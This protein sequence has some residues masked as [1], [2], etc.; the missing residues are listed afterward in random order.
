MDINFSDLLKFASLKYLNH[1]AIV[2]VN[3]KKISYQELDRRVNALSNAFIHMGLCKNDKLAFI[4]PNCIEAIEIH[5]ATARSGIVAI[6]LNCNLQKEKLELLL[7]HCEPSAIICDSS[8]YRKISVFIKKTPVKPILICIGDKTSKHFNYNELV[9]RSSCLE[10]RTVIHGNDFC[11]ILYTSG[12]TGTPKGAVRTHKNNYWAAIIMALN[13]N[14]YE[15]DQ[16]LFVLPLWSVAFYNLLCPNFIKGGTIYLHEGF[17]TAKILQA[18]EEKKITRVYLVPSMW[19]RLFGDPNFSNYNLSS[20]KQ[21]LVGSSPIPVELGLKMHDIFPD[22]TIYEMWGMTEGGLISINQNDN[23]TRR[24]LSS[25]GKPVPFTYVRIVNDYGINVPQGDIG[26]IIISGPAVIS[27]YYKS[28]TSKDSFSPGSWF[29]T[30]DLARQDSDG[31]YYI[32]GRKS[33]VILCGDSNVYPMEIEMVLLSHPQ[34][35]EVAVFG[36]PDPLLGETVVAAIIP[37]KRSKLNSKAINDYISKYLANDKVPKHFFI[38]SSFPVT[39]SGKII[40]PE[41]KKAILGKFKTRQ[42]RKGSIT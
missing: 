14:Y 39:S 24:R 5:F 34:I 29:R 18:I 35:Q 40:K 21:A 20:L 28:K 33:D 7:K 38:D 16:E 8:C 1:T 6:P 41:V 19:N 10:P 30:G 42:I 3:G 4:L 11:S 26:E 27:K 31:Y 17:N 2:D 32:V 15:T 9:S 36:V 23:F 25:T 12:T 13:I 37:R 22:A